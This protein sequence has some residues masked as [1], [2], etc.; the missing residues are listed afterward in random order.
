VYCKIA[1]RNYRKMPKGKEILEM[2]CVITGLG[3]KLF[4]ERAKEG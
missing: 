1:V 2:I 4:A 3:R